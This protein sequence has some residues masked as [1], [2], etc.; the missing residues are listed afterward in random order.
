MNKDQIKWT[1]KAERTDVP[2]SYAVMGL[3]QE[4][5]EQVIYDSPELRKI[6]QD[7]AERIG[8]HGSPAPTNHAESDVKEDEPEPAALVADLLDALKIQDQLNTAY[9]NLVIAHT[10]W[11]RK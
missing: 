9:A 8:R 7:M 3:S 1:L 6:A 5:L 10:G 2:G 11:W 4:T